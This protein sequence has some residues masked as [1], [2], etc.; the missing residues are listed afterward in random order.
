[1]A[2]LCALPRRVGGLALRVSSV[3][4]TLGY[5]SC[6]YNS[7][8]VIERKSSSLYFKKK[9]LHIILQLSHDT[10]SQ[11]ATRKLSQGHQLG[12]QAP[13]LFLI[14]EAR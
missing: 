1:M 10:I 11:I 2:V 9:L 8:V 7:L 14:T 6:T 4:S 5:P 3:G 13:A 12:T